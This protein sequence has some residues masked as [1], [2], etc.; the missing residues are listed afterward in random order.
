MTSNPRHGKP[1]S[2][3]QTGSAQRARFDADLAE[4]SLHCDLVDHIVDT[5]ERTTAQVDDEMN[6]TEASEARQAAYETQA[7]R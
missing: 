5:M 3:V 6:H 4:S 1:A 2:A 7:M